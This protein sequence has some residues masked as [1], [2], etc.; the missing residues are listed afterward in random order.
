[1]EKIILNNNI[2]ISYLEKISSLKIFCT[3]SNFLNKK[4]SYIIPLF[5]SDLNSQYQSK[6]EKES[7]IIINSDDIR[8]NQK[9]EIKILIAVYKF[10]K[11]CKK[12]YKEYISN[13]ETFNDPIIE[14]YNKIEK[15]ESSLILNYN[16]Y[17]YYFLLNIPCINLS[18]FCSL[19]NIIFFNEYYKKTKKKPKIINLI[20][21]LDE[22]VAKSRINDLFGEII[23]KPNDYIIKNKNIN[24]NDETFFKIISELYKLFNEPKKIIVIGEKKNIKHNF[25]KKEKFIIDGILFKLKF[26]SN[27]LLIIYRV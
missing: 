23:L 11:S 14:I 3:I 16:K 1:M 15:Y 25:K 27:S 13:K 8:E 10:Y 9:K 4:K 5:L 24:F 12:I 19:M 7:N 6:I 22:E 17:Y 18:P 21:Y 2:I 26:K 20:L